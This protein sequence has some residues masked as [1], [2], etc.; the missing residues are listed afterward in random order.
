MKRSSYSKTLDITKAMLPFRE[1][2]EEN[3]VIGIKKKMKKGPSSTFIKQMVLSA[4]TRKI[5]SC[6]RGDLGVITAA[7]VGPSDAL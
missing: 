3:T 7:L 5:E 6:L 1:E 4:A 2:G